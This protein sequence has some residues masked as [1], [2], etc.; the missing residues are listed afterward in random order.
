MSYLDNSISC[1]CL[2]LIYQPV[3]KKT[4]YSKIIFSQQSFI[5][6]K[7][8]FEFFGKIGKYFVRKVF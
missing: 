3:R 1:F 6:L 2:Q 7:I 8:N 5:V 4:C